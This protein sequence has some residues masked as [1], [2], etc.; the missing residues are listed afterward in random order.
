MKKEEFRRCGSDQAFQSV[1]TGIAVW[2]FALHPICTHQDNTVSL[3]IM[4]EFEI[5]ILYLSVLAE[6]TLKGSREVNHCCMLKGSTA[7][8]MNDCMHGCLT[9]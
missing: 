5:G 6:Q 9:Q 8:L 7:L 1:P 4:E 2:L 3:I